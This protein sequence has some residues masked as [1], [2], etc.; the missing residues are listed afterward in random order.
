MHPFVS[1]EARGHSLEAE[2]KNCRGRGHDFWP[3]GHTGLEALTSLLYIGYVSGLKRNDSVRSATWRI[4]QKLLIVVVDVYRIYDPKRLNDVIEA[5][6]RSKS[7]VENE[8]ISV[9]SQPY[10]AD[11]SQKRVLKAASSKANGLRN[12]QK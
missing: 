4:S 6:F 1:A 11:F 8:V 3:R 9:I 12:W 2:A 5:I 10:F 7:T